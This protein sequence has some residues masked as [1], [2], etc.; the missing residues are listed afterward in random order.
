[1]EKLT[2]KDVQWVVNDLAELGVK[3]GDQFFWFYKGRSLQY[4]V[5]ENPSGF[6]WRPVGKREFGET[7]LPVH[8]QGI[9]FG[10]YTEGEGWQEVLP[11]T[12]QT[13]T[14]A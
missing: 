6:K 13:P 9:K 12:P 3:I 14:S 7:C 8:L 1:M 2:E 4:N 10:R 11:E 5:G